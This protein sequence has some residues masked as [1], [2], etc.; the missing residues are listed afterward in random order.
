LS[1]LRKLDTGSKYMLGFHP[2]GQQHIQHVQ[3]ILPAALRHYQQEI[4]AQ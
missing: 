3:S 4:P 2:D 1:L